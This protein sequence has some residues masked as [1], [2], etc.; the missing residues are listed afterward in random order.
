MDLKAAVSGD[1]KKA[2]LVECERAED[3]AKNMYRSAL[4][5]PLPPNVLEVVEAQFGSVLASHDQI[6]DLR[7]NAINTAAS[8]ARSGK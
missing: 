4:D 5:Q 2:V 7:D 1:D 6:K 8:A 3:T